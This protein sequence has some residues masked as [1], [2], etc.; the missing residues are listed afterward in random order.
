MNIISLDK[1][2]K[3]KIANTIINNIKTKYL[4]YLEDK[5][6][7][8]NKKNYIKDCFREFNFNNNIKQLFFNYFCNEQLDNVI[9]PTIKSHIVHYSSHPYLIDFDTYKKINDV[10]DSKSNNI[11]IL[12]N[13]SCASFNINNCKF[14]HH[15][16]NKNII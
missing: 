10:L 8:Y 1:T 14:I 11:N 5:W 7:F 13:L 15:N 2:K 9:Y 6:L 4:I 3:F 16:F 12:N